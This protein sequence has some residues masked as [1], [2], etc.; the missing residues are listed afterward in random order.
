MTQKSNLTHIGFALQDICFLQPPAKF[1]RS[2]STPSY[3]IPKCQ[4]QPIPHAGV[5]SSSLARV[6]RYLA[7][8]RVFKEVF[9]DVFAHNRLSSLL[10]KA[11]S[12]KEIEEGPQNARL[13]NAAMPA[14]LH[15]AFTAAMKNT[16][17]ASYPPE[18]LTSILALCRH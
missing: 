7:T 15:L 16:A 3:R 18:L 11:K 6:L 5:D 12:L 2:A 13:D 10:R 4:H 9:P 8:R 14:F 17:E 1:S